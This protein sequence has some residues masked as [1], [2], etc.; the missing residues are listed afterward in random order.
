M[1][2]ISV[3]VEVYFSDFSKDSGMGWRNAPLIISFRTRAKMPIKLIMLIIRFAS[4]IL[5]ITFHQLHQHFNK[6]IYTKSDGFYI[7]S[8]EYLT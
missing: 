8:L 5:T 1:N 4:K 3:L 2:P 6:V 7:I